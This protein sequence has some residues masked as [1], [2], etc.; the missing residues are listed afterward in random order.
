MRFKPPP[1]HDSP[2]GWRVEI[3]PLDLSLTDFE[4]AAYA[5]FFVLVT[6][7][8][9][10]FRLNFYIPI[11]K[12]KCYVYTL[13]IFLRANRSVLLPEIPKSTKLCTMYDNYTKDALIS[14][15]VQAEENFKRAQK[16]D[17][18]KIQKFYF[19]KNV[20]QGDNI[21]KVDQQSLPYDHKY[22]EMSINTILNG[23]VLLCRYLINLSSKPCLAS[24]PGCLF[25]VV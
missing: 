3:R 4:N 25:V 9:L 2:I 8:I 16:R 19:R 10:H 24:S 15:Y 11:S 6:R 21:E 18:V 22:T 12:V 7:T 1:S 20:F 17:A 23:E 5:V 14:F 13:L